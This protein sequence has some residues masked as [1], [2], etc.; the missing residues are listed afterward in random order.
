MN[1]LLELE[2]E[3]VEGADGDV[4]EAITGVTS[5]HVGDFTSCFRLFLSL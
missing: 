4:D 3:V 5:V 2:V 1:L